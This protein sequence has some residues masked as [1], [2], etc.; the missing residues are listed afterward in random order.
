MSQSTSERVATNFDSCALQHGLVM[1][2]S[3]VSARGM[4][5][6]DVTSVIQVGQPADK[7]Q[8]VHRLGRTARAGKQGCGVLLLADF[9]RAFLRDV[10]VSP[11]PPPASS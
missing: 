11:A 1:F 2:T 4:D 7:A 10:K 6:P 9:E 5:Y 8:Y 3:D